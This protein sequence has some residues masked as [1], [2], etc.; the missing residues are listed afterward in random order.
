MIEGDPDQMRAFAASI[1]GAL[2]K[3][4]SLAE[5]QQRN[6]EALERLRWHATVDLDAAGDWSD[7]VA[8]NRCVTY[9]RLVREVLGD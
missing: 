7:A 8:N 2:G 1:V 9:A 4:A 6:A 5:M 3:R